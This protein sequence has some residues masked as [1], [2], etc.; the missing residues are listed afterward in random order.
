MFHERVSQSALQDGYEAPASAASVHSARRRAPSS[1]AYRS[2]SDVLLRAAAEFAGSGVRYLSADGGESAFQGYASLLLEAERILGGLRSLGL[3]PNDRVALLLE[4][5]R[6]FLPCFWACLLGDF[7]PCALLP[8][9]RDPQRVTARLSRIRAVIGAALLVTSEELRGEHVSRAGF[10]LALVEEMAGHLPASRADLGG[11]QVDDLALLVLTSGSTGTPKAVEL[12]HGNL[13]ASMAAKADCLDLTPSDVTLNWVSFD[14]VAASI[15]CHMLPMFVGATQLHIETRAFL[16]DPLRFL[17]VISDE[18]VT[19]T[20]APNFFLAQINRALAPVPIAPALDLSSLRRL[21][22]GGEAVVCRTATTFLDSLAGVGL[23]RDVLWPEFGMTETCAGSV[24]SRAFPEV[25][26]GREFASLGFPIRGLEMRVADGDRPL[27]ESEVGELQ[28]RGLM[29][30]RGYAGDPGATR[31]AFTADGWFRT[32]DLGFIENGRLI[33]AGRRKESIIV[34]GANYF[35]QAIEAG[36][37]ELEG[38]ERSCTA[39][40]PTRP[41]GSDTEQLVIVFSADASVDDDRKLRSLVVA[42]RNRVLLECGFRPSL[43]LPL[44]TAEIPRSSIGKI[45]RSILRKRLEAGEFS[46]HQERIAD[47]TLRGPGGHAPP[48]GD[49]E[50]ALAA[51]YADVLGLPPETIGATASFFDLG[52]TSI[53]ILLLRR[54]LED[55]LGIR[56]LPL[57]AIMQAQ[58]V[59]QLAKRL[60]VPKSSAGGDYNPVVPLQPSGPESPLFCIH[61]GVGEILVFVGL[62][63]SFANERP[64]YA[65]RARG[66]NPGQPYFATFEEMV[67]CYVSGIRAAQPRGPYNLLG[68]SYGGVVAFEIAKALEREGERIGLLGV[69]DV[70]P[71]IKA[72]RKSRD[73]LDTAASLAF[74]LSLIPKEQALSLP[75]AWRERGL[76]PS[77]AMEAI[78][79]LMRLAPR[80]RLDELALDAPK[81]AAWAGV[82]YSLVKLGRTYEPSGLVEEMSVF[83]AAPPTFVPGDYRGLTKEAWFAERLKRWDDFSRRPLRYIDLPAEHHSILGQHLDLFQGLLRRELDRSRAHP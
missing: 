19:M 54:R 61:P 71:H 14:H 10:S 36:I 60:D 78:A 8:M 81:F 43:I 67:R 33:L 46:G 52:G 76:S 16:E 56:D 18:R 23:A 41:S 6:D 58:T 11:A 22:S 65:L 70:P 17:R 27:A 3:R 73:F 13:L 25:D 51:I 2:V 28:L 64:I 77:E 12:T 48:E 47:V 31:D 40:F 35:P 55:R 83:Y 1:D 20:F 72:S 37:E 38:V 53:E 49:V 74:L 75:T 68:Y 34:N 5:A 62:V 59:R 45:G 7:V 79:E 4:R 66:F 42:I 30:C 82:A 9:G 57:A 29:V 44:P 32:G 80:R 69:I 63:R 26:A 39:A 21:I 15:E 50:T 24:F